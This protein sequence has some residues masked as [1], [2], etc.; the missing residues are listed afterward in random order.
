MSFNIQIFGV[1]KMAKPEVVDILTKIVSQSDLIAVQEVRSKQ[2]APVLEFMEKLPPRFD[3]VLG[4]RE[5][6]SSSKEQFWFIFNSEKIAVIDKAVF[7]D[8]DGIFERPP[9]GIF[10]RTTGA[11]DF[12]VINCHIQPSEA[13]NEISALPEV[14]SFFRELWHETDIITAG[15]FNSDGI[16]FDENFLEAVFPAPLYKILITNDADTTLAK[17]DN[18]YDRLII[19]DTTFEDFSGISGVLRF[20]EVY[21][22]DNLS[23]KPFN[24]SDHYPIWA[25]FYE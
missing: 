11:F 2:P 19:T 20:D 12:I 16:Y 10:C 14:I 7:P 1:A 15:D 21:D 22:F 18:T 5:G 6:R 9:F 23:I 25:D 17:S 24:V 4:P 3:Y 13:E 8:S